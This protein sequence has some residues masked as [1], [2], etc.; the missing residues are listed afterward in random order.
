MDSNNEFDVDAQSSLNSTMQ[1]KSNSKRQVKLTKSDSFEPV[2]LIRS[3]SRC[4]IKTSA[5]SSLSA[6]L[7]SNSISNL[8]FF[9]DGAKICDPTYLLNTQRSLNST[10]EH[11]LENDKNT[12][13]NT[14]SNTLTNTNTNKINR[15]NE[16][17]PFLDNK[18]TDLITFNT[19]FNLLNTYF[20]SSLP[21]IDGLFFT[22]L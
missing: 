6:N 20:E 17:N 5:T 12:H 1:D 11:G 16:I 18:L 22:F 14:N 9:I 15:Q 19:S 10:V 21:T 4:S 7:D 2:D 13:E 3:P 8:N